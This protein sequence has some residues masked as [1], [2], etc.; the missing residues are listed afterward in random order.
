[1][2][3]LADPN[4]APIL[5]R[6][7]HS[8]IVKILRQVETQCFRKFPIGDELMRRGRVK[9]NQGGLGLQWPVRYKL[10]PIQGND[11][12]T[13]L[14]FPQHDQHLIASLPYRGFNCTDSI[15]EKEMLEN[16]GEEAIVKIFDTMTSRM[17]DS[18]EE[19]FKKMFTRD[20]SGSSDMLP[21][22]IETLFGGTQTLD[23]SATSPAGRTANNADFVLY[24][25]STYATLSTV[26]GNYGGSYRSTQTSTFTWPLGEADPEFDFWSPIVTHEECSAMGG[27]STKTWAANA[28]AVIRYTRDNL[29]RNGNGNPEAN[30]CV[31]ERSKFTDLGNLLDSKEQSMVT[32]SPVGTRQYGR[33]DELVIDGLRCTTD[34]AITS[35][36]AYIFNMADMQVISMYPSLFKTNPEPIYDESSQ[37]Y[38]YLALALLN[39]KFSSPAKYAKIGDL[40]A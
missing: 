34:Y 40:V 28:I 12:T 29:N 1:M 26:L 25:N 31:M 5:V 32:T 36:V 7:F 20:G 4:A 33:G 13:P 23:A 27:V 17:T 10:H 3:V 37:S 22:G 39:N 2:A 30:L 38:R 24:P 11:G 8:N 18:M 19:G 14:T 35:K 21:M 15:Y 9:Y 6:S 16:R